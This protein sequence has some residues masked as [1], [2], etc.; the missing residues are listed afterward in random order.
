MWYKYVACNSRGQTAAGALEATSERE[1]ERTLWRSDLTIINLEKHRKPVSVAEMLPSLYGVKRHDIIYFTRDLATLLNSG[2]GILPALTML[3]GRT[4]KKGMKKVLNDVKGAVET[5]S[6]FSEA[7]AQHPEAFSPF[8][9]RLTKVGE[10]VG[11][12]EMMLRQ[13][14]TQMEKEDQITRKVRGAM[15]YPSFVLGIA[16]IA[17]FALLYFVIPA[18]DV[19]FTQIG[20]NLPTVTVV[21]LAAANFVQSNILYMLLAVVL[22]FLAFSWYRKT[23]DGKKALGHLVMKIPII[24]SI[25]LI[26]TMTQLA[27]N[28]SIMVRGGISLTECLDLMVE[29]TGNVLIRNALDKVRSKVHGGE[30]LSAALARQKVFPPLLSQVVGVGEA[31]GRLESNLEVLADFYEAEADR[32]VSRATGLLSPIMV[33]FCGGAVGVIAMAIYMPIYSLMGQLGG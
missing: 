12:L 3:H 9:L 13:V 15:M 30:A 31:S 5:G 24:G 28:I 7:C 17:I 10:E 19:L 33:V 1:A 8:F 25:I 14:A 18:M 22:G 2:I 29:T 6:S 23:D 27:R 11:N 32:A 20:G 4:T 16:T 26:G 21:V